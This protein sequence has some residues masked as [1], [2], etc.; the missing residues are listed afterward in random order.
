MPDLYEIGPGHLPP[1]RGVLFDLLSALLDSWSLWN[2]IAGN[3][4]AGRRW[5][6]EYLRITYGTSEYCPYSELVADAAEAAGLS[7]NL[8]QTLEARYAE[9]QPWPEARQTLQTLAS[10]GIPLGIVTNCS[11]RLGRIAAARLE[12][13]F[14]VIVTAERA[15]FYKP[16][17]LPYQLAL[18][19]LK[20]K[21]EQCLFVAG[22]PYD[23]T[24]T[25]AAGLPTFW[26]NRLGLR[27]PPNC[28]VPHREATS[29]APL[30]S[31][32]ESSQ[33]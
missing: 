7:P 1:Y 28:P 10:A 12:V 6:A 8:A 13:D 25:A 5:R 11:E 15:G 19:E 30:L 21:P 16:H 23:L 2:N 20:L 9:L 3:P 26:H 4:D 31:Q 33:A 24:G 18:S 17:P 29:L 32:F 27:P 22:S 14:S